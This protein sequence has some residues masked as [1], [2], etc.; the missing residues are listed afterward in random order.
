MKK[1]VYIC[2][3]CRFRYEAHIHGEVFERKILYCGKCGSQ[4]NSALESV[5]IEDKGNARNKAKRS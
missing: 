4:M 5:D 2:S 1:L 3:N